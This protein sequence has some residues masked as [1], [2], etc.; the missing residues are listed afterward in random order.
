M[1]DKNIDQLIKDFVLNENLKGYKTETVK[2]KV[3][4]VER[5][6][7][8]LGEQPEDMTLL[9]LTEEKLGMYLNIFAER[10]VITKY[11]ITLSN[12]QCFYKYL[13]DSEFILVNPAQTIR[14]IKIQQ[15]MNFGLFTEK[16]IMRIL[17]VI[18]RTY[19]GM[20]DRA[21]LEL[22]YS[23]ALRINE[24]VSLDVDDV[25]LR[26]HEVTVRYGKNEKQRVAPMGETAVKAL[27][28]YLN[29]RIGFMKGESEE[30][31]FLSLKG[32]RLNVRSMSPRI[33]MY[34]KISGVKSRGINHAFRHA[35]AS[36]MLKNGAP[37]PVIQQLLGH[38]TLSTT[39]K[40]THVMKDDLK[41]IH[42]M[43][44]PKA[45]SSE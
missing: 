2:S 4:D 9:S 29:I 11:N 34:K 5:L 37:L 24:L 41:K 40:Y 22:L 1:T 43:S 25:D 6:N 21:I 15:P 19:T 35:C 31:L 14:R 42:M 23:S 16:E 7:Q 26:N 44:H 38:S 39:V 32:G 27:H 10:M 13:K 36:H 17:D 33:L 12:I 30:A 45:G 8:Y 20:R 3:R 18:P 28:N